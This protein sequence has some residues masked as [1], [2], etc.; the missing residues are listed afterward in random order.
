M[1]VYSDNRDTE[2]KVETSEDVFEIVHNYLGFVKDI[3][4]YY[5]G[6]ISLQNV[7]FHQND[8]S[9]HE[10]IMIGNTSQRF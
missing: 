8:H 3:Q 4:V 2:D 9:A 10:W 1:P 5:E 7:N 6:D